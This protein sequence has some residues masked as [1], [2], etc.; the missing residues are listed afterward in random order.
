M[1]PRFGGI[2]FILRSTEAGYQHSPTTGYRHGMTRKAVGIFSLFHHLKT[3]V[4][5][6]YNIY[7]PIMQ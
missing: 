3:S 6:Y 5:N 7:K 4:H 1:P 2:F